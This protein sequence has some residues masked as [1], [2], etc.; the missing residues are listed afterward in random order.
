MMNLLSC[1]SCILK[2]TFD[3]LVGIALQGKKDFF[4]S[5]KKFSYQ[6]NF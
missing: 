1:F 6:N 2:L 4:I 3:L 5:E